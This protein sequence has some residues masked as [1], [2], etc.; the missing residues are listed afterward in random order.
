MKR[1]KSVFKDSCREVQQATGSVKD[2]AVVY[3]LCHVMV[4]ALCLW[5]TCRVFAH[6]ADGMFVAYL[7]ALL[8]ARRRGAVVHFEWCRGWTT[9]SVVTTTLVVTGSW[10][11]AFLGLAAIVCCPRWMLW[12]PKKGA[13]KIPHGGASA[14]S[15]RGAASS[16]ASSLGLLLWRLCGRLCWLGLHLRRLSLGLLL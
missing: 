11:S 6:M 7:A 9:L 15:S 3:A 2:V 10:C 12:W 5:V 8:C 16:G 1:R 13:N 4:F 14:S